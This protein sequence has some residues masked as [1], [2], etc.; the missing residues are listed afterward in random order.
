MVRS[1]EHLDWRYCDRR[2]GAFHARIAEDEQGVILGYAIGRAKGG[3]G[4]LADLLALPGR[5]DVVAALVAEIDAVLQCAGCVDVLCWL[6][7]RH[8]YRAALHGAGY[9]DARHRPFITYRPC[10]ATA[11]ELEFLAAPKT[12]V[13]FTI[14][15]TD[16]V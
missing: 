11:A 12:R 1:R 4:Y 13:H 10:G 2:A 14:G 6:P 7:E 8:P 15:D 9:L 5:Q 3:Q 16:L